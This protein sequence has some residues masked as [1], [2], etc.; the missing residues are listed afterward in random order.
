MKINPVNLNLNYRQS[1]LNNSP[2]NLQGN[3]YSYSNNSAYNNDTKALNT[4]WALSFMGYKVHLID[5]GKHA[6]NME[7][8]ANAISKD[9]EIER[10]EISANPNFPS[11]K[12]LKDVREHL[13][14]LEEKEDIEGEYIA[15]PILANISLLNMEAQNKAMSSGGPNYTASTIKHQPANTWFYISELR[16]RYERYKDTVLK[17]SDPN[18]QGFEYLEDIRKSISYLTAKGAKVYIPSSQP[19]ELALKW[20]AQQRGLTPELEHFIATGEDPDGK[21]RKIINELAKDK[22]YEFNILSF[23]DADIVG[24]KDAKDAQDYVFSGYDDCITRSERGVYNFTP[25]RKDGKIIGYSYTDKTTVQYPYEEFTDNEEIA[26]IS[27][28]VGKNIK[29][30]SASSQQITKLKNRIAQNMSTDDCADKLYPVKSLFTEEEIKE[31]KI[32]LKGDWVDKTLTLF[33]RTNKENEVIYPK[34]DC[35]GSGKPSVAPMWGGGFSVMNAI[36][37]DI[38]GRKLNDAKPQEYIR[39]GQTI[40]YVARDVL[41]FSPAEQKANFQI[42]LAQRAKENYDILQAHAHYSEAKKIIQ[43]QMNAA[44]YTY[45]DYFDV[46]VNLGDINQQKG[47]SEG[48]Y[49]EYNEAIDY[50]CKKLQTFFTTTYINNTLAFDTRCNEIPK[51][52]AHYEEFRKDQKAYE[53]KTPFLKMLTPEPYIGDYDCDL[54]NDD[55]ERMSEELKRI[56]ELYLKVA[57]IEETKGETYKA[58]MS[59]RAATEIITRGSQINNII[60]RRASGTRF[61]EDLF[62]DFEY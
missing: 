35:E 13:L 34:F 56:P 17:D 22:R 30:T 61:I 14:M 48:A 55:I 37:K 28:F 36:A 59:R 29:E 44:G 58:E 50:C 21:I 40:R 32:N 24:I 8:F 33:F 2:K 23:S 1:K 18:G 20:E 42:Q 46:L 53:A 11:I 45:C 31:K 16:D 43:E 52:R 49:R 6:D 60:Q 5:G 54:K 39:E 15:I 9:M 26:N 7:H 38:E 3:S 12:Q 47:D 51:Y 19:H 25:V 41:N 57:N 10:R 4:L 62:P 27:K